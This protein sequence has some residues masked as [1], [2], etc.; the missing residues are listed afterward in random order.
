MKNAFTSLALCLLVIVTSSPV[1]AQHKQRETRPA[2]PRNPTAKVERTSRPPYL[3]I[4]FDKS[5]ISLPP[6]F[7][8]HS[9]IAIYE[10]VKQRIKSADKDEFETTEAYHQ[11]IKAETLKPLLGV[12]TQESVLAFVIDKNDSTYDAD[13]GILS[14]RSELSRV[15]SGVRLD[16]QRRSLLWDIVNN[17]RSSYVGTNAYGA[18]VNVERSMADFYEISFANHG[19]FPTEKYLDET[20]RKLLE[21]ERET[22][23]RYGVTESVS[24][25]DFLSKLGFSFT[26]NMTP[27][28]AKRAKENLRL[29]LV[30]RLADPPVIEGTT[31][32]KPTFDHPR[33]SFFQIHNLNTKLLEVWIFNASTGEVYDKQSA[34]R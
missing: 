19:E 27:D 2:V 14:V 10:A 18:K 20:T 7:R 30:C 9:A 15:T 12:I 13:K 3:S 17:E 34:H 8:G 4:A 33:E 22:Y 1:E 5:T 26:L 6:N 11:R 24:G 16:E 23:K 31:Y 28:V 29:L 21:E 32:S 25:R